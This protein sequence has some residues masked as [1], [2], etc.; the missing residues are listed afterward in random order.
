MLMKNL[1]RILVVSVLNFFLLVSC[2]ETPVGK[3]DLSPERKEFIVQYGEKWNEYNLAGKFDSV[4]VT[5]VPLF[6][7]ALAARDTLIASWSGI[8]IAQAYMSMQ[9][10]DSV[11]IY[12]EKL[13]PLLENC[14]QPNIMIAYYNTLGNYALRSRLD[15]E[16][17]V[18]MFLSALNWAKNGG[19]VINSIAMAYDIVYLFYI[20]DD[21][22]GME[23]AAEAYALA[24]QK[25]DVQSPP[26]SSALT[27]MGMMKILS[28]ENQESRTYLDSAR[29][30]VLSEGYY[31][32]VADIDMFLGDISRMEGDIE[33]AVTVYSRVVD[34]GEQVYPSTIIRTYLMLGECCMECGRTQEALDFFT[35]GLSVSYR[36]GVLEFRKELLHALYMYWYRLGEMDRAFSH[37]A[38]YVAF[39]DTIKNAA[40]E[41]AFYTLLRQHKELEHENEMN[42]S[43]IALQKSRQRT[44]LLLL[45]VVIVSI[46][47]VVFYVQRK[48]QK[49][50]YM[51]LFDKHQKYLE[52]FNSRTAMEDTTRS[53]SNEADKELF[54]RIETL[55]R[56]QKVFKQKG[57]T[58]ESLAELLG[59]NKTYVSRAINAFAG[60]TFVNYI[61]AYRINEAVK[62]ISCPDSSVNAKELAE[63][64]GY[65]S[66]NVFYQVF[67]RETGL[68]LSRYRKELVGLPARKEAEKE[69]E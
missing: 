62:M 25:L 58:R 12:L 24:T 40:S 1:Y 60:K 46:L 32:Q 42:L 11:A 57:L 8:F 26:Y 28:G 19:S 10:L 44:V 49:R 54:A 61:N 34:R 14:S 39:E 48:R 9:Q 63:E 5:T 36:T 3:W 55:M 7:S 59:T 21:R 41:Q 18:K 2:C 51:Q 35:A 50:M 64:L 4:V 6:Q 30:V 47:S 29:A 15:Y 65:A 52:Y 67:Q 31:S 22:S 16:Q 45:A 33:S 69:K 27:M 38:D 17:A 53:S 56:E 66:V 37:Y 43:A 23:Y 68:S 13:E 20:L